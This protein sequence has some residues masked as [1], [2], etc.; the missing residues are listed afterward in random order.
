MTG[1]SEKRT[2]PRVSASLSITPA[3]LS[4]A[5]SAASNLHLTITSHH[6]DPITIYA[7]DL[8]PN[9]MLKCG[10]IVITSLSTGT[11]V[12]QR[13]S[14]HCRIP[15]Q[16][17]VAVPLNERLFYTL[18][19]NAP[20]TFAAPFILGSTRR[21]LQG[22]NGLES[23]EDYLLTLARDSRIPWNSIRWWEYG[24]K[25]QVLYGDDYEHILDGRAVRF[26]P[27]PHEAIIVESTSIGAVAFRYWE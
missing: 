13:R 23:G 3:T 14:T 25:E 15:L 5:R 12:Q 26:G 24:T 1:N 10:A 22:V 8:S 9:L 16:S 6:P 4:V 17:K 27:G 20:L 7:D 18:L 11:E 21:G 19:P 2:R